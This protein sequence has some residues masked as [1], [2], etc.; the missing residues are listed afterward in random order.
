MEVSFDIESARIES[1]VN[2]Q[3][4]ML[5][6]WDDFEKFVGWACASVVLIVVFGVLAVPAAMEVIPPLR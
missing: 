5:G 1:A 4:V 2:F 6:S 3:Q